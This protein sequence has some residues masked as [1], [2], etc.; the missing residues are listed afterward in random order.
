MSLSEF[1]L[2]N[3]YTI[4]ALAMVIVSL[5]SF[6]FWRVPTDLFPDTVPPQVVIVTAQQGAAARD[7]TNNITKIIE[8]ELGSLS[9]LKRIVSTS[10]DEV[11]SINAEFVYAKP[12]GE[13]VIDVQNAISRI[14]GNLPQAITEPRLYRITDAT[15]P[16]VTLSLSPKQDSLKSLADIR[17]LAENDLKDRL[18]SISGVGD[19]QVFGGY[20]HEVEVRV[21]RDAL[22]AYG[23]T[24]DDVIRLLALQNVSAPGGTVYTAGKEHLL[25]ISGEFSQMDSLGDL[26]LKTSVGGRVYL[27][28]VA[29]IK[30][31]T[32]DRRSIYH[33]NGINA[34]AINVLRP[35][36]GQTVAAINNLKQALPD[37]QKSY[38][39][40]NFDITDDQ[41]PLIDLNVSGMRSS[42]WQA[43]VLTVL[44]ILAFLSN[45]R[46]ASVVSVAIPLS[47]L[48]AMVVLWF[49][50]YTLNMVTLSGLIVAVG[51]VVD[52]SVVVL[53]NIYRHFASTSSLS[54][55]E[56]A[57]L[58]AQQVAAPI[59]AG[60]LTT[61]VVLVPVLFAGGYTGRIMQPLNIM[62]ISTLVA[63]LLISLTVIPIMASRLLGKAQQSRKFF[64][65]LAKPM[66][67]ALD[68]LTRFYLGWVK[69]A[70]N[71][72]VLF[73]GITVVFLIFTMRVVKPLLGGEQ[74]PPMDTGIA[75]VE[76]DTGSSLPPQQVEAVLNRVEGLL[77]KTPEVE[78]ISAVVGSEIDA[79]SF[80]GGGGTAQAGKITVHLSP[81]TE[82]SRSIWQIEE[83]WRQQLPLI[84]GLRT[85][86]VSEYGATP[87]ATT[88]APF[89]IVLSGPD[90]RV[91]DRLADK[92]L[93]RLRGT[94]GLLDLR[95]TWYQ[96]KVEQQIAVEPEL[97]RLYATSPASVATVLR[98][99]VQGR[100]ASTMSLENFLDIPI[101][102]RY[103]ADQVR[104]ISQL[105]QVSVPTTYG[106]V[107]LSNL[108]SIEENRDQPFL[109]RENLTSTIDITAGNQV[110]TIAEVTQQAQ[111]RLEDLQLPAGYTLEIAGTLRDMN[112]SGQELGQ[113]L[114]IGLV[115]LFILLLALF[116]SFL[117]P[118]T[119]M[120]SIPLAAAGGMWGLLAFNKPFCMPALMGIILLGGTIVNNA[121]LML[122][123]IL[124]ARRGGTAKDEAILQ[125]VQ[126]RLR[127][128]LMTAVSTVVGF[129]PLIFEMAVGLERMSPLGI[130]AASGLLFGTVV[131]L[132]IIPVIYS[133]LDSLTELTG[134]LLKKGKRVPVSMG[135]L[136]IFTLSSGGQVRAMQL[137][138]Q[139]SF[140]KAVDIALQNNPDLVQ[141][142]A[143]TALHEGGI[144]VAAAPG[145]LQINLESGISSSKESH[146][147]V[148]GL[149]PASQI[150]DRQLFQTTL[151]ARVL[152]TDFGRTQAALE[153]ATSNKNASLLQEQRRKQEIIFAVAKEYLSIL[154]L[155]DLL[156][157]AEASRESLC[158][159]E[160]KTE[161]LISQGRVPNID[162]LKIQLQLA[163]IENSLVDYHGIKRK[164]R[165][166]LAGLLGLE[167][168]LPSL[169][170]ITEEAELLASSLSENVSGDTSRRADVAAL[171]EELKTSQYRVKEARLR[172]RPEIELWGVAGIYGADD[173]VDSTMQTADEKWEDDVTVG[174]RLK[175][176]LLDGHFRNGKLVQAKANQN[177]MKQ[178]LKRK[179]IAVLEETEVA[180]SDLESA[181][182]K[183]EVTRRMSAQA[184]EAQRIEQLKYEA[185][186]GTITNV[187]DSEAD[188]LKTQSL[189]AEAKATVAIARLALSLA[190]GN[191]GLDAEG[192]GVK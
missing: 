178:Q 179:R 18:L 135:L 88:K 139:L 61:V 109:T 126:L 55:R 159:L 54:S 167:Q 160:Q 90:T 121:I 30:L 23:L 182:A 67:A 45:L 137:P 48:S 129:S 107:P 68:L 154:A 14:R 41:Q 51:M 7:V 145:K 70:L 105:K 19:V 47:F 32:A 191:L 72:R 5:G 123:F 158:A 189:A 27:R 186:K 163:E 148:P 164:R 108:A 176:P 29:S 98:T 6:A 13:A 152:V 133:T 100:V 50:P 52:A 74:M 177:I 28:N 131:T 53:E 184:Q 10:R 95:R 116:R 42:L 26:P 43:V 144:R 161:L 117:H 168:Q 37:I 16:L 84:E 134:T 49:S 141:A 110:L 157:A 2:K 24:L 94:P 93:H 114:L 96:D 58:G 136:L 149:A 128:I 106:L 25:R 132:V 78:S 66:T 102:V 103:Q 71:H 12:I 60:M 153:A 36:K 31:G 87:V 111:Q 17:L 75:I 174:I 97:A 155:D 92:V 1:S 138:A 59:T 44:V 9:G 127:P 11:S 112:E 169:L 165:A 38:P 79:I 22:T 173:P 104:N 130:A 15:R 185:G 4:V 62:I 119:I 115:L 65:L 33:G 82:R 39:D 125:S 187:L 122:D 21:D 150:F 34:V 188:F 91:L 81:R 40:I 180:H 77:Q 156:K 76:F 171:E 151:S 69:T 146:A 183:L 20:R 143:Q 140:E 170:P 172:Y 89:N 118:F 190:R 57:V 162:R 46:A 120:L 181:R 86:R 63:S 175:I 3:P 124:E 8:K 35:E 192:T 147:V 64:G 83:G 85:F 73:L 142:Q 99:A 166:V 56:A 101:R 113:A 80:S